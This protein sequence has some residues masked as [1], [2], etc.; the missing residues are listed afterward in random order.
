M[1]TLLGR[2][3][4]EPPRTFASW[5]PEQR[6]L[7]EEIARTP[8]ALHLNAGSLGRMLATAGAIGLGGVDDARYLSR[9]VGLRDRSTLEEEIEGRPLWLWLRLHLM[10]QVSEHDWLDATKQLDSARRLDLARRSLDNAYQWMRRWPLPAEV[11]M[12]VEREDAAKLEP[13]LL[14]I[15]DALTTDDLEQALVAEHGK[16]TIVPELVVL[17]SLLLARRGRPLA[18]LEDERL[19]TAL[20][21][22]TNV[23]LGRQ[24]IALLPQESRSALV[25]R[26]QLSRH[27]A[28]GWSRPRSR[29][30]SRLAS[31]RSPRASRSWCRASTPLRGMPCELAA[32]KGP[33]AKLITDAL[34]KLS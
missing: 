20:K 6:T 30:S 25:E 31:R 19:A 16:K 24:L 5:N 8:F 26:M 29:A 34:S 3:A 4:A 1:D 14:P 17:L 2:D 28:L 32:Q 9:Y 23:V 12:D 27:S 10:G 22:P 7:L 15:M 11:T 33:N 18:A 21:L 13:A